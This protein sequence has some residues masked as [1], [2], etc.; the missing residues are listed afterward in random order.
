[1]NLRLELDSWSQKLSWLEGC[2][3]IAGG[4]ARFLPD[5]LKLHFPQQLL[6]RFNQCVKFALEIS[7]YKS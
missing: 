6:V 2:T 7:I 1:M 4:K 5:D 3:G